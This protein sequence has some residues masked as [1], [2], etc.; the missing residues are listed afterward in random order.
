M[1]GKKYTKAFGL[2]NPDAEYSIEEAASKL[3]EISF[4][5]FDPTVEVAMR[6]GVDPKHADQLVRG[7]VVLPHGVGKSVRVLVMCKA[8]KE[9]EAKAAGADHFGLQSY[10][11]KIQGGW[12]DIDV[13]V[14][15]PDVMA[16]VGKLGK[17]LGPK[18]LMPNPK[19][20]TVT[21][22]VGKA[23]RELKAGK[24]EFR[25]DKAGIVHAG[26][27]KLSFGDQ[28]ISENLHAFVSAVL[29]AK[30]AAAKGQYLKTIFVSSSMSPSLRIKKDTLVATQ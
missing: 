14:A 3:K 27:G 23:V 13:I 7:T 15:T 10:V 12:S 25:V 29:R 8:N 17:V 18:G 6:L 4:T 2:L 28:K 5:K 30:P 26:V 1:S 19:S 24:I 20:G 22:D 21:M 11:E 16:E 9:E